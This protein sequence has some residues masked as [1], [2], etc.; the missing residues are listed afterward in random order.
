[1]E[2]WVVEY[3][4][5]YCSETF[6]EIYK[7]QDKARE[8]FLELVKDYYY[9]RDDEPTLEEVLCYLENGGE[10]ISTDD[11][12]VSFDDASVVWD[13]PEVYESLSYYKHEVL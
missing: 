5:G 8:R 1:M 6:V 12:T 10:S 11:T 2:V 3:A 7:D 13:G 9:E 4:S